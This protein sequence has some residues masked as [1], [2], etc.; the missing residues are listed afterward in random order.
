MLKWY[1]KTEESHDVF[2]AE[3]VRLVRNLA[4]EPFPVK[5]SEEEGKAL[6][7]RMERGMETL[8]D[9]TGAAFSVLEMPE[10][11]DT[12]K[13]ALKERRAIN[14]AGAVK[15]GPERLLLSADESESLLL[16]GEDHIRIQCIGSGTGL[17]ALWKEA[18]RLDDAVNEQFPYAFHEKYGYLTAY[19]TN[20]GTGLRAGVTL[21]LPL[22]SV[23][24]QFGKLVNEIGRFGVGGGVILNGHIVPGSK[25]MGG[26]IGH[27]VMDWNWPREEGRCNCNNYGCLE[28]IASATGIARIARR[29]MRNQDMP[30]VLRDVENVTAKD[31]FDAAKAGDALAESVAAYCMKYLARALAYIAQTIDPEVFVIGGGVSKAGTYLLDLLRE[32]FD[33][34]ITLIKEKPKLALATLGNDAGIYGAAKM[35]IED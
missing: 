13:Q 18:D 30:S 28:Q 34:L 1:Q 29:F 8:R 9:E 26:E 25:G 10:L 31:V 32:Q 14:G 21:H 3:R 27:M 2:V 22:L 16:N 6:L 20:V 19:P 15:K 24:K 4:H 5:L 23:G 35:V 12:E 11:G 17:E 7:G 33:P